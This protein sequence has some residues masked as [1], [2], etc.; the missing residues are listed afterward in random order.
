MD[1]LDSFQALA[2]KLFSSRAGHLVFKPRCCE[3][4]LHPAHL[5]CIR[6]IG[7]R[8][9]YLLKNICTPRIRSRSQMR[10]DEILD[11]N[12]QY[13]FSINSTSSGLWFCGL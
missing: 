9:A 7:T 1:K 10:P 2:F 4:Q 6:S 11:I 3:F 8:A 5:H 12:M 13:T